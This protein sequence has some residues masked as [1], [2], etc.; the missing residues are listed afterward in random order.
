M[1]FDLLLKIGSS[2]EVPTHSIYGQD[3]NY[4]T[5]SRNVFFTSICTGGKIIIKMLN[6]LNVW[7][8]EE[9]LHWTLQEMNNINVKE[10]INQ[11]DWI[12]H[13]TQTQ[14]SV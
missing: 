10:Q 7:K 1:R 4:E 12:E 8:P 9:L 3:S 11:F 13:N 2:S 14:V 6:I 5:N